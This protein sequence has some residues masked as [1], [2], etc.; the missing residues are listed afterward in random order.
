MFPSTKVASCENWK[1]TNSEFFFA[2]V[3]FLF[4]KKETLYFYV[5]FSIQMMYTAINLF[6]YNFFD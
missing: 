2:P 5:E 6:F 4:L 1:V 3:S